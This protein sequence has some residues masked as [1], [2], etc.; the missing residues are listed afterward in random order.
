MRKSFKN[1]IFTVAT[2]MLIGV[3]AFCFTKTVQ[4]QTDSDRM[5]VEGYY[6]EMEREYVSEIRDFLNEQGFV[7]SGVTLTRIVDE[8]GSREYLVTIHHKY[9]DK[10]TEEDRTILFGEI[11]DMAFR[12]EECSF[13]VELLG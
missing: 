6:R 13:K 11:A 10:M 3:S 8:Q 1:I 7:N 4:G 2:I 12:G 5:A 9:L